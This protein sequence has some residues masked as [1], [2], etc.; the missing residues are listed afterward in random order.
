[1]TG[2][3]LLQH[4]KAIGELALVAEHLVAAGVREGEETWKRRGA[5]LIGHARAQLGDGARLARLI[6]TTPAMAALATIVPSLHRAGVRGAELSAAL[7]A[8][9]AAVPRGVAY[10]VAVSLRELGLPAP[11]GVEAAWGWTLTAAEPP[12]WHL[13]PTELYLVL[14]GAWYRAAEGWPGDRGRAYVTRWLPVWLRHAEMIGHHDLLSELIITWHAAHHTPA[15]AYAWDVLV[16]AQLDDGAVPVTRA[17]T[18]AGAGALDE[19]HATLNAIW[20]AAT[21]PSPVSRV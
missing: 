15:P 20:A 5:A 4:Y 13:S 1:M 12:P 6:E 8:H 2:L 3:P 11:W 10:F 7:V 9:A 17:G 19:Y 18:P 16:G 21:H 14:H